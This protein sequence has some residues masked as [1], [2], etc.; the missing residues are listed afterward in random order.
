MLADLT[1]PQMAWIGV[2]ILAA[3]VVRGMSGFGAGLVAAPLLAFVLPVHVIV[4]T[5]GL[6]VFILFIFLTL[7]DRREVIW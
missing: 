7:R 6:L 2:S 3:Y 4:P 5:T 1:I